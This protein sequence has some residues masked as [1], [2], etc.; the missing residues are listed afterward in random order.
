MRRFLWLGLGLALVGAA[1]FAALRGGP[2]SAAP[3]DRI[4]AE[5]RHQLER[6]L[7]AAQRDA[8]PRQSA[9]PTR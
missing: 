7:E 9:E 8:A 2:R 3:L 4:D 5:S 6:V 1:L